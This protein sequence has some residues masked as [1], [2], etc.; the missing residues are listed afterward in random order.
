MNIGP[1]PSRKSTYSLPRSSQM[2]PPLPA[3]S[4]TSAGMLPKLPPGITRLASSIRSATGSNALCTAMAL[5]LLD[6]D[7]DGMAHLAADGLR[8]MA[9]AVRV[10]DQEHL[11]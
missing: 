1:E 8:E 9:L 3:R 5:L 6:R 4:I 7:E 2:R 10:L 11:A